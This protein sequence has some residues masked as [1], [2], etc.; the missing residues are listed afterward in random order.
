[1]WVLTLAL[2]DDEVLDDLGG[3]DSVGGQVEDLALAFGELAQ[4][5]ELRA[6]CGTAYVLLDRRRVIVGARSR[7][8][9][10]PD[11]RRRVEACR[12]AFVGERDRPRVPR[13]A[14]RRG[15]VPVRPCHQP[16]TSGIFAELLRRRGGRW[17]MKR[18]HAPDV[19]AR[20]LGLAAGGDLGDGAP[21][22]GPRRCRSSSAQFQALA[23]PWPPYRS[24]GSRLLW[25]SLDGAAFRSR[26]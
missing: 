16:Q 5:G 8:E 15:G 21:G 3:G 14:C 10:A 18:L 2:A 17:L 22:S 6:G 1:M 13:A 25:P 11:L 7:A 20:A 9:E 12:L 24:A 23:K 19:R 26:G 4:L